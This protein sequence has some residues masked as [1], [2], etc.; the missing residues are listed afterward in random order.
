MEEIE[1]TISEDGTLSVRC[2]RRLETEAREIIGD[3]VDPS[4]HIE[5]IYTD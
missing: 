4:E 3:L 1:I 5:F 2:E